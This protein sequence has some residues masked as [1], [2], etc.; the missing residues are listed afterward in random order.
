MRPTMAGRSNPAR[1]RLR[2]INSKAL[3]T[4][5]DPLLPPMTVGYRLRWKSEIRRGYWWGHACLEKE[6]IHGVQ[7]HHAPGEFPAK[8]AAEF[9]ASAYRATRL[10]RKFTSFL[11]LLPS[12]PLPLLRSSP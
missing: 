8:E 3:M 2:A 9:S 5:P 12:S 10:T 6:L 7:I 4:G 1:A 11:L